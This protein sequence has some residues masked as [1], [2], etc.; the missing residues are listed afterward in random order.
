MKLTDSVEQV[1]G[2]GPQLADKFALLGVHTVEDL[3]HFLPRR[4]DD[5]SDL[6]PLSRIKPGIVSARVQISS[7]KGRYVR[8][9]MHITEAIARDDTGSVRLIW[10]NQPYR[11]NSIKKDAEYFIAGEFGLRRQQF[12]IVNPS[13]E[14]VSDFPIN[15]ARIVPVYRQTKGLKSLAVRRAIK[16]CVPIMGRLPETLPAW[17]LDQEQLVSRDRA[18]I[19]LHFPS[20]RET[21]AAARL[22][23]GFEEVFELTLAA[24]L[25]KREFRGLHALTIAFD[26]EVAKRCAAALPFELTDDQRRAVWQMYQDMAS[27]QP[28]NRLLQGDVGSGKTAVALMVS[29]MVIENGFQAALMAPTEVLARQ[30]EATLKSLLE[31]LDATQQLGGLYGSM[32]NKEKTRVQ[33]SIASG[34]LRLIVGT[35][36]LISES[37]DMHKLGLVIIDEQHR[38]G[39]EQRKQLQ[40]KAGHMPH[41]L[42]MSA[43][44]I[45]RSIALTLYGD[46]DISILRHKPAGRQ[47]VST[48]IISPN[49]RQQLYR[50]I[51]IQLGAG[52]QAFVVCP[53]IESSEA[54]ASLSAEEVYKQLSSKYLAHRR[55]GLLHGKL[56]PAQKQEI[57]EQFGA[58]QLDVLVATTVIEVGVDVPN[59]SVM[60]VEGADRFGL[61]QLHQ[62]RGRIGRGGHAGQCYLVMSDS[63]APSQRLRALERS[64][65]GFALADLDLE[66]RGPG[67]IY[68]TLQ[69]GAL[70]LRVASLSDTKLIA[71]ARSAA[72]AFIDKGEDISTYP[73]LSRR[74][75]NLR[76]ITNLS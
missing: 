57:M 2:V 50:D 52:R 63:S 39:V 24:L 28:M 70:D 76:A 27:K 11:Q 72:Q 41:V 37:V 71:R 58:H 36:A 54:V 6:T 60:V 55:I 62:L 25:N 43:T 21:F 3:I 26:A 67:A 12:S 66:L 30:H 22:R 68:G 44:P 4:Y 61:A 18:L 1:R 65:D 23:Y 40:A 33:S 10:F 69:H 75:T 14:L 15:T 7:V 46:L 9:G 16:Q 45:P 32:P 17:L 13:I 48:Q 31:P 59:A 34:E 53:L 29:W 20:S 73:D 49:S 38:F 51:D 5:Y 47:A 56:K 74:V 19:E 64:N 8:R 35:H 42:H